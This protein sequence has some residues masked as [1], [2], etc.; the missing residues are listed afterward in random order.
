MERIAEFLALKFIKTLLTH[1]E[2]L[3]N[4]AGGAANDDGKKARQDKA[5]TTNLS[6]MTI[7]QMK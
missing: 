1:K 4:S 7:L 2:V 5:T 6:M 3:G